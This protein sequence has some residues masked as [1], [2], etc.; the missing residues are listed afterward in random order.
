MYLLK[1]L[2]FRCT[3]RFYRTQR[4]ALHFAKPQLEYR[5]WCGSPVWQ[6]HDLIPVLVQA[7]CQLGNKYGAL[8]EDC[9]GLLGTAKQLGIRVVGIA[10][11]VGSGCASRLALSHT[12]DADVSSNLI[13]D[14][15]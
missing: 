10:F 12:G 15:I 11:H 6:A 8:Q 1:L 9:A 3:C 14:L 7:R 4:C 2:S 13:E 5:A